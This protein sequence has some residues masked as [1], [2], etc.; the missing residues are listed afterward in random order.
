MSNIVA[1]MRLLRV[2]TVIDSC[3]KCHFHANL[4][5]KTIKSNALQQQAIPLTFN[6]HC[7]E[8]EGTHNSNKYAFLL[9]YPE[10]GT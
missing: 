4:H 7:A 1:F 9:L 8:V 5:G 2:I 6:T 10:Q 3:Q